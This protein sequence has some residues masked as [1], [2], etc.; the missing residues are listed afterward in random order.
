MIDSL[1]RDITRLLGPLTGS[2]KDAASAVSKVLATATSQGSALKRDVAQGAKT[3]AEAAEELVE[4][5][6]DA[7]EQLRGLVVSSSGAAQ[8]ASTAASVAAE[9][10]SAISDALG[11]DRGATPAG[12][13][14]QLGQIKVCVS[15]S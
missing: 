2:N 4:I 3:A 9:A 14:L 5:V 8:V 1:T 15:L 13:V 7:F 6:K 11:R 10:A 12:D